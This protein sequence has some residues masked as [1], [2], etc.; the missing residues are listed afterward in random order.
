[1]SNG[2]R[3]AGAGPLAGLLAHISNQS[4]DADIAPGRHYPEL[5]LLDEFRET[6]TR[7]NTDR[8][9][10][11]S[12]DQVPDNAGP[13]NSSHLMRRA[14]LLMQKVSPGYM[15]HFLAHADA[16]SSLEQLHEAT[17]PAKSVPRAAAAGRKS[18]RG[19]PR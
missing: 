16:L 13:L 19:K 1:M 2:A 14:L 12:Q 18:P 10:R 11:Q 3:H 17:G 15:R 5:P 4:P 9:L 8:Q 7:L 6:W